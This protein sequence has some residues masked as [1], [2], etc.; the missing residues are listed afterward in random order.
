MLNVVPPQYIPWLKEAVVAATQDAVDADCLFPERSIFEEDTVRAT[1]H[2]RLAEILLRRPK[3]D[4]RS[5]VTVVCLPSFEVEWAI[6]I[7]GSTQIGFTAILTEADEKIFCHRDSCSIQVRTKHKVIDSPLA[8]RLSD[9]WK[10]VLQRTRHPKRGRLGRDGVSYHFAYS[11]PD[12]GSLAGRTR[13]PETT[14]MPG[15]LVA[16]THALRT[17]LEASEKET[18]Q[19]HGELDRC[20][21]ELE[22]PDGN[23]A[24]IS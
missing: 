1:Y 7:R 21:A 23:V 6:R 19:A 5:N 11:G 22:G 14:T 13:S 16:I 4:P 3:E 18:D 20:I 24:H 12:V 17:Y 2:L 15:R 10:K 8:E 9:V